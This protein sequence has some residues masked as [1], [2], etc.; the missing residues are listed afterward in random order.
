[1]TAAEDLET[2]R[3]KIGGKRW[4]WVERPTLL[5]GRATGP[6][7]CPCGCESRSGEAPETWAAMLEETIP[8][9]ELLIDRWTGKRIMRSAQSEIDG[10]LARFDALKRRAEL[11]EHVYLPRRCYAQQ[12]IGIA[13]RP[14]V[15]GIFGGARGGK[16]QALAEQMAD[17]WAELGGRNVTLW[18][19]APEL[20]DTLRAIRKL[21]EGEAIKGGREAETRPPLFHPS[22]V[23][24]Y[25]RTLEHVKRKKPIVL[26]D[27][28][29]I[30]L[31]YAG[32]SENKDGGQLK[33]DAVAFIAVD[34]G[35]EIQSSQA[36]HTLIQRTTDSGGR[37]STA[38]TPKLGSPLKHLVYDEGEDLVAANDDAYL[39]GYVHLSM[40]DNPWIT[41][42][43]AQRTIDTLLKE[44]N[45]KDLVEQDVYGRW[46]TPGQRM[47]EHFDEAIHV[48]T[49]H[50]R[51]IED[52]KIDGRPLRNIT[53]LVAG[54]FFDRTEADLWRVAG[55]D[56]ND[57][58]HFTVII[59][60][61][62]PEGLDESDPENHV[63]FVEDEVKKAGEVY[64]AAKFLRSQA[65]AM[66][67]LAPDYFAGMAIACDSTGAQDR[68]TEG[69]VTST[70][71]Q[72]DAY[73]RAGFDIRPCH[74]SDKGRPVNPEKRAQ[75]AVAHRLMMRRDLGQDAERYKSGDPT[76]PPSTRLIIN[77]SRCPD[78]I[79]GLREQACNEKGQL[80]KRSDTRDDIISDP[81]DA[82]LY[83][84]W[85][86]FSEAEQF[87][88]RG[89]R[90][91][92]WE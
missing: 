81:V 78:L 47:W 48:V 7:Q 73:A 68:V 67:A 6:G 21:I 28:T 62:C 91:V 75:Q 9:P 85:A 71:T 27:G 13:A 46:L 82:L 42:A 72:A 45:G 77:K 50:S 64:Q 17:A 74:R 54:G 49:H 84:L 30:E 66:R 37:L 35:A 8:G 79:K 14:K 23:V 25:P 69:N 65:G 39:T 76:A 88:Q 16:T 5:H 4:I 15:L 36:W 2:V 80:R 19:V 53:S 83:I 87:Q 58:G 89:V 29:K 34:E 31:R 43:Q 20:A 51:K 26:V 57:R 3:R 52:Y 56:F 1:M 32:R 10:S 61:G 44:P 12:L 18:W 55:Q 22:L 60:I 59:Q 33:G 63:V 11:V 40:L 24:D 41:P 86:M 92:I 70:Y 90:A 38:T